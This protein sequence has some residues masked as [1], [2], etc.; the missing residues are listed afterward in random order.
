MSDSILI[1][2][3]KFFDRAIPTGL[4]TGYPRNESTELRNRC[5]EEHKRTAAGSAF[6]QSEPMKETE[7]R[8]K[9]KIH[10]EQNYVVLFILTDNHIILV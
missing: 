1:I 8:P 6:Q 9:R 3:I 2:I 7:K 5:R 10:I 4:L